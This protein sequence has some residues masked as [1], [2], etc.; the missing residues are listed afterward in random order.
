MPVDN[1]L[2]KKLPC[3][4]LLI[5]HAMLQGDSEDIKI[6]VTDVM[7][8]NGASH[9]LYFILLLFIYLYMKPVPCKKE[10]MHFF[11]W[12]FA[13]FFPEGSTDLFCLMN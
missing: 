10:K 9:P 12:S 2:L 4:F 13:H 6:W 3:N 5:A 7:F 8:A 11:L 1:N